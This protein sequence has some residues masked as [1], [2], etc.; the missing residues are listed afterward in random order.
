[1]M[2]GGQGRVSRSHAVS[3]ELSETAPQMKLNKIIWMLPKK[4][5]PE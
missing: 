2:H 5:L 3:E 4:W 1:M